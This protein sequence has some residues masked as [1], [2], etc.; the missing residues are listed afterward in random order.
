MTIKI[1]RPRVERR[2]ALAAEHDRLRFRPDE[3]IEL[4]DIA[5]PEQNGCE[6]LCEVGELDPQKGGD[7]ERIEHWRVL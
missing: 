2:A 6:L 4:S 3:L 7:V 1:A 5:M